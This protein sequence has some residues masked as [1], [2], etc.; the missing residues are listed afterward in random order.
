MTYFE[1]HREVPIPELDRALKTIKGALKNA[2]EADYEQALSYA[3]EA[4][5]AVCTAVAKFQV[6]IQSETPKT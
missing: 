5:V 6:L 4:H 3:R 2:E 1:G